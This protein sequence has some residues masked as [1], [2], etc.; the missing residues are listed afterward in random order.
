MNRRDFIR[1]TALVGA[2]TAV[3]PTIIIAK[4]RDETL[5]ILHTNDWHSRIDPF[6]MDGGKY[7]GRGGAAMRAQMIKNIRAQREH[8]L[9][10]DAGDIF[11][12]TPYFNFYQGDPEIDLMNAMQY[13]AT[14]IGNHDFDGGI[15][16]LAR[17]VNRARFDFVCANYD[18]DET[19]LENK[20][21]SHRVFVRGK[22]RVGIVGVGIELRGLVPEALY[23]NTQYSD[24]VQALNRE[25]LALKQKQD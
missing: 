18:F 25:A 8:V 14:T 15:D 2:A 22:L 13:D 12:G 3:A 19:P 5:T 4:P 16:G 10:F 7:Q 17:Q 21:F 20:I 11:Q 24:P 9:L 1:N 23:T 6:P